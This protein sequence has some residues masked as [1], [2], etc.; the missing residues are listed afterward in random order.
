MPQEHYH[1]RHLLFY[2]C[3]NFFFISS[4]ENSHSQF[5]FDWLDWEKFGVLSFFSD[6]RIGDSLHQRYLADNF[7]LRIGV[8]IMNRTNNI[9]N[10]ESNF[11][12]L[13]M[14]NFYFGNHR[15]V[16]GNKFVITLFLYVSLQKNQIYSQPFTI[17][18]EFSHFLCPIIDNFFEGGLLW[19]SNQ[20]S[21]LQPPVDQNTASIFI[22]ILY[23]FTGIVPFHQDIIF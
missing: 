2:C 15:N 10:L 8:K 23:L 7:F 17:W 9:L 18:N 1:P 6:W 14:L 11:E 21:R 4:Y 5:I 3:H 16:G 20:V 19:P 13:Q 12:F 22:G